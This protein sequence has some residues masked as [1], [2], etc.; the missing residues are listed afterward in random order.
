MATDF[1]RI[2]TTRKELG[3]PRVRM[4]M[5]LAIDRELLCK[6][7]LIGNTPAST[8]TPEMGSYKPDDIVRFDPGRAKQLLAEAGFPEGRG[9]PRFSILISS[10]GSKAAV[11]SLQAM[12]RQ[13]LGL[14]FDIRSMDFGSYIS[15]QQSLDYDV[16]LAA[17]SGDYLDPTT[18]LLMWTEGNG[19]NNTG[20]HSEEYEALLDKAAHQTDPAQRL[21]IFKQ[22]E[23]LLMEAQPI[24]PISFRG[25]NYLLRP[26]VKNWH[27]L[28]LDNH[29]WGSISLEP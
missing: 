9:F 4:A 18:F 27:P 17:W 15:A 16:A 26:E 23:H 11:E 22:A 24:C 29:P 20:W 10:S 19:N 12:W 2:N 25:R 8:L 7:V 5:S 13:N 14:I 6:Y 28:L 1:V 21:E 3:D